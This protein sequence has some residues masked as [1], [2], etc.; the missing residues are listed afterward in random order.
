MASVADY[1]ANKGSKPGVVLMKKFM[2]N[3]TAP[4]PDAYDELEVLVPG[5][6]RGADVQKPL[7]K[8]SPTAFK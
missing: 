1:H 8:G 4:S 5:V 2:P 7:G 3:E 6:V